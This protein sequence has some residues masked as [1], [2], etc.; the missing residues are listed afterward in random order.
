VT[1]ENVSDSRTRPEDHTPR[2][3]VQHDHDGVNLR[4]IKLEALIF[5]VS[6]IPK[7]FSIGHQTWII[8]STTTIC[9]MRDRSDL[10][11]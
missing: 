11:K 5:M 3:N 4:N 6:W 9:L 1:T 10:L 7:Y 2:Y 8:I